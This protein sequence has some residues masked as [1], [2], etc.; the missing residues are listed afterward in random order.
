GVVDSRQEQFAERDTKVRQPEEE[1]PA[2]PVASARSR[3]DEGFQSPKEQRPEVSS[4]IESEERNMK[5]LADESSRVRIKATKQSKLIGFL[6]SYENDDNG[7]FFEL[8]NGRWLIT[9]RSSDHSEQQ[10]IIEDASI[11]PLHAI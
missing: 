4:R 11:S 9:S 10:I 6:I 5:S 3:V 8:R 7:E 2:R 1:Y